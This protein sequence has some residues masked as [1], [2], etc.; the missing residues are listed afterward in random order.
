V[1]VPHRESDSVSANPFYHLLFDVGALP[2]QLVAGRALA[3]GSPSPQRAFGTAYQHRSL[4]GVKEIHEFISGL[5]RAW[6][7]RTRTRRRAYVGKTYCPEKDLW[8]R[9]KS[10]QKLRGDVNS[11]YV[12]DE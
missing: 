1:F 9:G 5:V 7:E 10:F 6:E 2:F 11:D 12:V 3:C 8:S 4:F